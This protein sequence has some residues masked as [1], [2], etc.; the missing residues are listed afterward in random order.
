MPSEACS[1][2]LTTFGKSYW[3]SKIDGNQLQPGGGAGT[4]RWLVKGLNR[5]K[6]PMWRLSGEFDH[7]IPEYI[8]SNP[9]LSI[10]RTFEKLRSFHL[11]RWQ[12]WKKMVPPETDCL[13]PAGHN[14][15]NLPLGLPA[16]YVQKWT[17]RPSHMHNT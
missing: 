5:Q 14:L 3:N 4:L 1:D 8:W 12:Q 17:C 9:I 10:T 7:G 16:P 15:I 6:H 13:P 2:S 11:F